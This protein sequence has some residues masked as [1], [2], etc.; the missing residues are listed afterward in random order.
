MKTG[1][2]ETWKTVPFPILVKAII[3][4][5]KSTRKEIA[6]NVDNLL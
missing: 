5:S 1:E 2:R 3:Y 4:S 6:E